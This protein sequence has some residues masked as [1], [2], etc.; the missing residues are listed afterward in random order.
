MKAM[1]EEKKASLQKSLEQLTQQAAQ[2]AEQI[3][4]HRGALQYNEMLLKECAD[5][6]EAKAAESK[7]ELKAVP[8]ETK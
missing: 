1:L 4:M 2:I 6:E 5:A 8:E 3:T 7:A